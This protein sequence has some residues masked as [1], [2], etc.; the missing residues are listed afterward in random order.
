VARRGA[1]L[2]ALRASLPHP[3]RHRVY[4]LDVTDHAALAT[5][6]ESFMT[7]FGGRR[8]HRQRRHLARHADRIPGRPAAFERILAVNVTA[9]FATFTPFVA[10][11]KAQPDAQRAAA[12]WSASAAWPASAACPVPG[13]QRLQGGRHQLLRIA[14]GGIALL[15]HQGRDHRA[16]LHRHPDDPCEH[17]SHALPDAGGALCRARRQSIAEGVSYRVIPWQMGV[18]AKLLRLLPNWLYDMAFARARTSP[19][20]SSHPSAAPGASGVFHEDH[21]AGTPE[22]AAVALEALYAAGHEITLVLTQPD[23]PAGRGMQLQASPVK[24]CA[25]KHGTPVAQPVS[26]RLNGKY[27]TSR[28]KRMRCCNRPRMT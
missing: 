12:A 17:L 8:G 22:F 13:L 21:F 3:E 11:M 27:R 16:R 15:R 10:R 5:A 1:E 2:E 4:A 14:A 7:E 6:A 19:A 20:I 25:F 28:R 26:L 24:Q 18:V 9:T 23:R